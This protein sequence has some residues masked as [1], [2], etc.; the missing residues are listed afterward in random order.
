MVWDALLVAVFVY[1][2]LRCT[3]RGGRAVGVELASFFVTYAATL[4][5]GPALSAIVRGH[6]E[7]PIVTLPIVSILAVYFM[8][9]KLAQR[10]FLPLEE[11]ADHRW[12]LENPQSTLSKVSGA[13]CGVLRG[14]ILAASVALI[15]CS[16][17]RL[18]NAGMLQ[19]I[20]AAAESVA[21]QRAEDLIHVVIYRVTHDAGP[22]TKQ[23]LALILRPDSGKLDELMNGPF[24][25]RIRD[26]QEML[27]FARNE[28]VRRLIEGKRIAAVL[29]HPA[30]LRVFRFTLIELRNEG[31]PRPSSS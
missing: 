8:V 13:G 29:T 21:V 18:Q 16:V 1:N 11:P 6:V 9:R 2:V 22:T 7:N 4:T 27:A 10:L 19:S 28:E 30:F 15:G 17:V 12:T 14:A 23:L 5:L 26:S 3:Q 31:G 24:V 20:P 25:A